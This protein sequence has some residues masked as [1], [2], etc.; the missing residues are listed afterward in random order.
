[1]S[2]TLTEESKNSISLTEENR[3]TSPTFAEMGDETFAE[4][5]ET[6]ETQSTP[7][8]FESKNNITLTLETK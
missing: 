1:M 6:F 4:N 3:I 8:A 7:F 2:I 5:T